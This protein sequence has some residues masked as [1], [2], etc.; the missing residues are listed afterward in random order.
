MR[1][2]QCR[3]SYILYKKANEFAFNDDMYECSECA[4][5]LESYHDIHNRQCQQTHLASKPK[6]ETPKL[7]KILLLLV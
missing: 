6:V 3:G 2:E 4:T 5:V 7:E 1:E